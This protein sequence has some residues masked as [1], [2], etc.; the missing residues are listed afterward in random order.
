M[1]VV[2]RCVVVRGLRVVVVLRTTRFPDDDR[3]LLLFF[4]LLLLLLLFDDELDF[5]CVRFPPLAAPASAPNAA[6]SDGKA[7][8]EQRARPRARARVVR[9][10][11]FMSRSETFSLSSSAGFDPARTETFKERSSSN[12]AENDDGEARKTR[13]LVAARLD[14]CY[15]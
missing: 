5:L 6:A 10:V 11:S 1:R 15:T 7:T 9:V 2:R 14:L 4:L 8:D 13:L 3:E 12:A